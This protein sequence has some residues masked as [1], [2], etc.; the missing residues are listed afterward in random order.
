MARSVLVSC[1]LVT[2]LWTWFGAGCAGQPEVEAG[3]VELE[4][5]NDTDSPTAVT[6]NNEQSLERFVESFDSIIEGDLIIESKTLVDLNELS[7]I[8]EVHG[9][10]II[11]NCARLLNLSGLES[12]GSV[13][14]NLIIHNNELLESLAGLSNVF[15]CGSLSITGNP[16]LESLRGLDSLGEIYGNCIVE[17]NRNLV[18][19]AGLQNLSLVVGNLRVINNILLQT[20][21]DLEV[22]VTVGEDVE[23]LDNE[24]LGSVSMPSLEQIGGRLRISNNDQLR[25]VSG[26]IQL[27]SIGAVAPLAELWIEDNLSLESVDL[28]G[29]ESLGGRHQFSVLVIRN[30]PKLRTKVITRLLERFDLDP[31]ID[32]VMI[33]GNL[34]R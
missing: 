2:L 14:G 32:S 17:A 23:I 31:E 10:L 3:Q 28:P 5:A 8:S 30:N 12:V 24:V 1:L 25:E 7:S 11:R 19:L 6:I 20:M 4:E 26:L 33:T 22:L 15:S 34:K 13:E 9:N 16:G 18:S 21:S 27:V 29:L